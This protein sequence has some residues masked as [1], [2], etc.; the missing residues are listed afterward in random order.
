MIARL[1]NVGE[2]QWVRHLTS[3]RHDKWEFWQ[4]LCCY[5][6]IINLLEGLVA[7]LVAISLEPF[8]LHHLYWNTLVEVQHVLLPAVHL[9]GAGQSLAF[10]LSRKKNLI[11]T[12]VHLLLS[13]LSLMNPLDLHISQLR[14]LVVMMCI[15][16]CNNFI[17]NCYQRWKGFFP[18]M[19]YLILI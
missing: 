19:S 8:L 13:L 6:I 3:K 15:F 17:N 9:W 14:K 1:Q 18:T 10:A 12:I 11:D 4:T 16:C 7:V 2:W 5:S